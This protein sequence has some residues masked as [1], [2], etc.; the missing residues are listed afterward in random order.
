MKRLGFRWLKFNAVGAIGIGVQLAALSLYLKGF[1][2]HY[3]AATALAVETA[4]LHNF[5]L[6]E[7]WTWLERTRLSGGARRVLERLLK[8]HL[9]NGAVSLVANLLAMRV[10]TGQFGMDPLVANLISIALASVANFLVGEFLVFRSAAPP[11]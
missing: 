8:F 3:L 10:L 4:I 2:L 7:R 11:A 9:G 1:G 5:L 6:H